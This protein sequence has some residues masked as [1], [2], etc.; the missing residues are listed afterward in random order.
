MRD[1]RHGPSTDDKCLV[2][3]EGN[4]PLLPFVLH[5]P[6]NHGVTAQPPDLIPKPATRSKSQTAADPRTTDASCCPQL[7]CHS[8]NAC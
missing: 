2:R 8:I 1:P 4:G 3:P 5:D 7:F 6:P